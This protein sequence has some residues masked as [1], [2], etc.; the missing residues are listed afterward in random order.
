MLKGFNNAMD[1]CRI[2]HPHFVVA[3]VSSTAESSRVIHNR[4]FDPCL[5]IF[6]IKG[7]F[8][9]WWTSAPVGLR[10]SAQDRLFEA[11]DGMSKKMKKQENILL[12]LE[13]S[14]GQVSCPRL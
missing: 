10:I 6:F 5:R 12:K 2:P 1:E 9:L 8:T 14:G 7:L 11:R 13:F 4:G 3:H